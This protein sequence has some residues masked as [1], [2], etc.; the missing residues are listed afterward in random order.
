MNNDE[1][2]NAQKKKQNILVSSIFFLSARKEKEAKFF[3]LTSSS[4]G[5]YYVIPQVLHICSS[6]IHSLNRSC[7]HRVTNYESCGVKSKRS[8]AEGNRWK[9]I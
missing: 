3:A 5:S 1:T 7:L 2:A 8:S 9:K 4:Q 6:L